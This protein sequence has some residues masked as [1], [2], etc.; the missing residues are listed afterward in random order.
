[1]QREALRA[2]RQERIN[3]GAPCW[4]TDYVRRREKLLRL[5][6]LLQEREAGLL[7]A[8]KADLGK[9]ATEAYMTELGF[10]LSELSFTLKHLKRWMRP[11]RQRSPFAVF[12]AKSL[13]LPEPYGLVLIMSPWNYPLQLTLTPLI[14]AIAAG[15]R[16]LLKPSNLSPHTSRAI[17]ELVKAWLPPEEVAVVLGGREENQQLLDEHFDYIF[18]TG[19]STVGRI[20]MQK[21]A[22][23]LT[24]ITLELGGKSP[25]I[26]DE[27]ADIG[28]AARRIA[29][30]KAL[31]AG[32]TCVA[33]DYL[34][35]HERVKVKLVTAIEHEFE[36]FFEG[37]PLDSESWP[38]IISQKHYERLTGLLKDSGVQAK[39][40][41]ERIAPC[42]VDA[43][44]DAPLMKEEIFGPIFPVISFQRCE[45][46]LLKVASLDKPLAFYLFSKDRARVQT[47][48]QLMPFGGGCVNDT[49]VHLSNPH[50]PFGG[51]GQSG[52]GS[53]HGR[54]GFDTFSHEKAVL[55][56]GQLDLPFRYPPYSEKKLSLLKHF[57][58]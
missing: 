3:E 40:D 42:L 8:L 20:V 2:E 43:D 38:R 52:M 9:S 54:K 56:R 41:G 12:P 44:W 6:A 14:S 24:P 49:V 39:G 29:F 28:L 51:V 15:N 55:W 53:Y 1:M 17:S 47:A 36:R 35:V 45:D 22:E 19:G 11:R 26:V 30:G 7:D 33:P 5:K 16:C 21:A 23:H 34:L 4:K 31:N 57:L 37:K 58:K 32:Q 50:L 46:A 13:V 25:C 18:F 48:L 10:A 27:T